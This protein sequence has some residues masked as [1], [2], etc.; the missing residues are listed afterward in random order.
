M[1]RTGWAAVGILGW[2]ALT[3]ISGCATPEERY[4]VLTIF[5]DPPPPKQVA[6][7]P[8]AALGE[9][10]A[11]SADQQQNEQAAAWIHDPYEEEDC[12][13]CHQSRYSVEMVEEG[14]ELCWGCHDPDEFSG[15]IVHG[16]IEAG[17]CDSCHHPHESKYPALLLLE[18]TELC[19]AC[20]DEDTFAPGEQH[21]DEK[22]ED[23]VGCHDPHA[24]DRRYMLKPTVDAL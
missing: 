6:S 8:S 21:R 3:L 23:C 22:G 1:N 12:Q 4:R 15:K 19:M 11:G 9:S 5:F 13:D 7:L 24:S 20:H 2:L 14:A 17:K 18:E 10:G 16:P